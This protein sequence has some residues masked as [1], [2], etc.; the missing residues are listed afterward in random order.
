MKMSNDVQL[1]KE[2]AENGRDLYKMN[3][4]S[5]EE[6]KEYIMPYINAVNAK[7]KELA[8]KYKV[9]AK[10]INFAGFLR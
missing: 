3:H 9:R 2:R 5:R 8:K 7:S 6:A 1:L 10:L 4:I